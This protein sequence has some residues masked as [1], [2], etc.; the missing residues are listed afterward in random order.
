MGGRFHLTRWGIVALCGTVSTLFLVAPL[1]AQEPSVRFLPPLTFQW[2]PQQGVPTNIVA[3][4]VSGDGRPDLIVTGCGGSTGCGSVAVLLANGDGTFRKPLIASSAARGPALVAVGDLNRDQ[5]SDLLVAD[6]ESGEVGVLLG[7]GDG[8]F[9][10][11]PRSWSGASDSSASIAVGIAAAD[12]NGDGAL[13]IVVAGAP[14][15]GRARSTVAIALGDG[16][17]TFR[18]AGA[19]VAAP[20]IAA[21]LGVVDLNNDGALDVVLGGGRR[22]GENVR[23]GSVTVLL[24]DGNG[25]LR[26]LSTYTRAARPFQRPPPPM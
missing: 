24:G 4:D 10:R 23:L 6:S 26:Q 13:D 19:G 21:T 3:A 8:T 1:R 15:T 16:D 11:A 2:A 25:G 17:G 7:S 5:R 12:M 9:R 22:D 18:P 14:R 20:V